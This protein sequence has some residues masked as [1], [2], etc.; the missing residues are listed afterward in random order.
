[1]KD[2]SMSGLY[3]CCLAFNLQRSIF[4]FGL[5]MFLYFTNYSC[6]LDDSQFSYSHHSILQLASPHCLDAFASL[7]NA[8]TTATGLLFI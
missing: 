5:L 1:M 4:S 3:H 8:V 6:Y 2:P 7:A